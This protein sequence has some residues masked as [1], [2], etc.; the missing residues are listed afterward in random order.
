M[1]LAPSGANAALTFSSGA[2]APRAVTRRRVQRPGV[3][4]S[5]A[6]ERV[7]PGNANAVPTSLNSAD[8][9]TPLAFTLTDALSVWVPLVTEAGNA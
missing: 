3:S 5:G 2:S 9:G 1:T 6:G 7:R 8:C 4:Q